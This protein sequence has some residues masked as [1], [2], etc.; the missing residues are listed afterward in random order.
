MKRFGLLLSLF[1]LTLVSVP[2]IA[3]ADVNNFTVTAF[4]A[5]ETLSRQDRQGELHIVERINVA[6]TDY[7]HRIL[8][9][10]PS[11]YKNHS[12][13]LHV[14]KVSSDSGAPTQYTTYSSN[15]NMVVK[16]G[17]PN[18]TVTG[19]Q[20]YAIDYTARNVINFEKDHDELYWD[21]NG[22]QWQQP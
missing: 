8:R 4:S 13:Q 11:R 19:A 5:D 14:N 15:G 10:I 17:D 1:F 18:R 16:I 12:L 7:N 20:Q 3:S 9:A 2:A 6:F 22:D 21:V